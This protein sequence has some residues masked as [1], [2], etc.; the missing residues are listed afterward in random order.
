VSG[1]RRRQ[2]SEVKAMGKGE[3]L[4][5][6]S[7]RMLSLMLVLGLITLALGFMA[8]NYRGFY[9]S[10]TLGSIIALASIVYIPIVYKRDPG[11]LQ[12]IAVPTIQ[13]LW[14]STSMGLGYVVTAYAPYFMLPFPIATTLFILGWVMLIAGLYAL[15]S[16]SKEAGVSLAV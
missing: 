3:E 4:K 7:L 12:G 8:G 1:L 16:I 11:N 6:K 14:I 13:S 15:L 9:L 10:L 2:D 5:R